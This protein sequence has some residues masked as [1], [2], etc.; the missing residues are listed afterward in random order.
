MVVIFLLYG[1]CGIYSEKY[2]QVFLDI[3]EHVVL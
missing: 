1:K 3:S 2:T